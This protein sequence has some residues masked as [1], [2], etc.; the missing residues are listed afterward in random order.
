MRATKGVRD[1]CFRLR[2][3]F[4]GVPFVVDGVALRLDES[5]RR[6]NMAGEAAVRAVL[7]E[8]LKPGDV[9]V[10]IGANF[11][12]HAIYAAKL[13]GNAGSVTGFEPAPDNLRLLRRNIELS[14]V[15]ER[16]TVVPQAVSNS[17]ERFLTFYMPD[18]EVAVTA[19]LKPV[20]ARMTPV[21][22]ENVRFDEY[23]GASRRAIALMKID[24]EG[25][26]LDVLRGARETLLRERPP[27][28]IEVHG[29]ALPDFGASVADLRAFLTE[30][31]Y[32]ER[33]L[34]GEATDETY[35]QSLFVADPVK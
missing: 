32:R 26:E 11:G 34:E 27:L 19:S 3:G 24:V 1:F 20:Q 5:L 6:W 16:V 31:E 10:D 12:M 18:E 14:G 15:R 25:A 22:V 21:R 7:R 8:T 35:F 9:F 29:F 13:V 33:R 23:W 17:P 2:H 30:L 28:V 4:R